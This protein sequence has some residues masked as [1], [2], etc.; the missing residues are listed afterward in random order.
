M[1]DWILCKDEIPHTP[2]YV[3]CKGERGAKFIGA[4]ADIAPRE[5]VL[6][7]TQ[8]KCS[9]RFAIAWMPLPE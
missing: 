5:K 3:L 4:I 2:E 9:E 7:K 1:M 6:F 8:D